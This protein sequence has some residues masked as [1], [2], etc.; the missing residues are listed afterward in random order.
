MIKLIGMAM[1]LLLFPSGIVAA[2]YFRKYLAF[3]LEAMKAKHYRELE[4]SFKEE[5]GK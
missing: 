4:E 5:L 3:K 1:F 2:N